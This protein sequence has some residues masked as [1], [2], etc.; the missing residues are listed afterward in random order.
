MIQRYLQG[1]LGVA[2]LRVELENVTPLPIT[3]PKSTQWGSDMVVALLARVAAVRT[4][5]EKAKQPPFEQAPP[6]RASNFVAATARAPNGA[7]QSCDTPRESIV[8][9]I[10]RPRSSDA[11][12]TRRVAALEAG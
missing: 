10:E 12:D 5:Q 8:S 2:N 4:N 9:S 6:P 7:V 11:L 3:I 1:Q